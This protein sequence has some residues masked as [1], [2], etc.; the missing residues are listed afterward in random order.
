M[1]GDYLISG[2]TLNRFALHVRHCRSWL[3]A[4]VVLVPLALHEVGSK[5]PRWRRDQE[6]EGQGT[7]FRS[8]ASPSTPTISVHDIVGVVVFLAVFCSVIFFF[9]E[10]GGY[11]SRVCQL[12]AG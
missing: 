5:Q 9:P 7:A 10:M 12:R 6:A 8:M 1:R 3:L 11:F 2:I 4:L